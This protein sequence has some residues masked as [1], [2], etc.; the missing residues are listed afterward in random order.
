MLVI[1]KELDKAEERGEFRWIADPE[2][3]KFDDPLYKQLEREARSKQ[4][5]R[6]PSGKSD[7]T[8]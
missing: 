7:Y 4:K 8:R 3:I 1:K 2:A 5:S 6:N